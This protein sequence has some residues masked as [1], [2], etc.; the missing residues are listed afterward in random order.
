M[1]RLINITKQYN[2]E[3]VLDNLNISFKEKEFVSILAPSG[4]GKTTL[5]NIIGGLDTEYQGKVLFYNHNLKILSDEK[6]TSYRNNFVS[7]IFQ[8]YNLIDI[9]NVYDNIKLSLSIKN[10]DKKEIDKKINEALKIL[11]I[12]NIKY[13]YPN[14]LSG[15]Q[16]QRVAVARS[17]VSNTNIIL[18][19]E[20]TSAL[21][22]KNTYKVLNILKILSKEKLIIFITHNKK[23]AKEYSDR[24]LY[25]NNGNIKQNNINIKD[26]NIIFN[27]Y[28]ISK[29]NILKLSI[30]NIL[31]HKKRTII[32]MFAFSISLI[33]ILLTMCISSSVNNKTSIL[34]KE[35]I[36]SFPIIINNKIYKDDSKK[37]NNDKIY[38]YD[39]KIH[40]NKITESLI[41]IL[42]KNNTVYYEKDI[43]LNISTIDNKNIDNKIFN[44]FPINYMKESYDVLSGNV[45]DDKYKLIIEVNSKN[46]IDPIIL[47][48]FNIKDKELDINDIL[49]KSIKLNNNN[50]SSINLRVEAVIRPKYDSEKSFIY[51][52]NNLINADIKS[53]SIYLKNMDDKNKLVK[54]IEKYNK[55]NSKIIYQDLGEGIS[56]SIDIVIKSITNAF[57]IFSF[58]S[59]IIS[60]FMIISM[61]YLSILENKKN[62]GIFKSLGMRNKDITNI[63]KYE[64]VIVSIF[65]S[66]FSIISIKILTIIIDFIIN[67]I[68][69]I[70]NFIILS[71]KDIF[72]IS[73]ISIITCIF[74][75]IKPLKKINKKNIKELLK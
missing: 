70:K 26:K 25:L 15:G 54:E 41:N 51:L 16:K 63:L 66:L 46:E 24:I 48:M 73:F 27:K 47:D 12:D 4:S 13:K 11:D 53:I 32:T 34:E 39:K 9:L 38:T 28:N 57:V 35:I 44:I 52:K 22:R 33:S 50:N 68:Y 19:D 20:V 67:K 30:K 3:K 61:I 42:E 43:N 21:D 10:K 58:I 2:D 75:T 69:N 55:N 56:S 65:T 40:E 36:K 74:A 17:I 6:L 18:C 5:L 71:F 62:I 23:I 72:I 7:F 29:L 31:S 1:L 64:F 45:T 14:E 60:F 8:D 37:N 49:N 59:L